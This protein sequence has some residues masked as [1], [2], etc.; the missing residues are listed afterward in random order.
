MSS[1]TGAVITSAQRMDGIEQILGRLDSLTDDDVWFLADQWQKADAA[2]RRRAWARAKAAVVAAGSEGVLNEARRVVGDWMKA[3]R[4]DFHGIEGLLGSA[5]SMAAGRQAAAPA[6]LDA[7]VAT[8]GADAL[9]DYDCDVLVSP[10]RSLDA[11]EAA[12]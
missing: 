1:H 7:V 5:G 2:A 8:L 4:T 11:D 6:V 10:W 3:E 9:D 12:S